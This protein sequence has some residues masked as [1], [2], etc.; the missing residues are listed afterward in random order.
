MGIVMAEINN[1]QEV[2]IR[3]SQE[4]VQELTNLMVRR[5]PYFRQMALRRLGNVAD[6]EDA[7]QDAFVSA[8]THLDQFRRQAQM[9]TWLTAIVV[10]SARM[11]V[12]STPKQV[13]I[14]LDSKDRNQHNSLCW[15]MLSDGRPGPEEVCQ[16]MELSE[17]LAQLSTRLSPTLRTAFHLRF[18]VGLTIREIAN[19]LGVSQGAVK[20]RVSRARAKLNRLAYPELGGEHRTI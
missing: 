8:F 1:A 14:P 19:N 3:A 10:N 2:A 15:E 7:V 9:S 17:R 4:G 11:K 12:R 13:H 18:V 20:A 16:R 6:A 5:M